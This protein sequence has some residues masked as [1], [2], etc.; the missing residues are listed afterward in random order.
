MS[1]K[2]RII[3]FSP[4]LKRSRFFY[5]LYIQLLES[6][7]FDVIFLTLKNSAFRFLKYKNVNVINV[8]EI[9][10]VSLTKKEK[11]FF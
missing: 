3:I 10:S 11:D 1:Y 2:K 8:K 7:N 9:N 4:S 5:N 6:K